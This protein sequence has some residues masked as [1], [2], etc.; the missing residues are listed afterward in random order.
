MTVLDTPTTTHSSFKWDRFTIAAACC[1]CM[2]VSALSIGLV[3]PQLR[4]QFHINGTITALHGSVL[5]VGLMF[6]GLFGAYIIGRL[7]RRGSL[8]TSMFGIA[9]G[10]LVFATGPSWPIT[11]AGATVAGFAAALMITVSPAVVSD[12]HGPHRAAAFS[13]LAAIPGFVGLLLSAAVGLALGAGASW[14]SPYL[15]F[16]AVIAVLAFSTGWSVPVPRGEPMHPFSF[17]RLTDRIVFVPLLQLMLAILT[18]FPVGMWSVTYLREV[19]GASAGAAPILGCAFA[20]AMAASRLWT[21]RLQR[22]LGRATVA[23]G[24]ATAA[25]GVALLCFVPVLW[26]RV[27]ALGVFAFGAGPL[28]PLAMDRLYQRTEHAIDPVTISTY[29]ALVNGLAVVVGPL[30]LGVVAD[31]VNLRWAVLASL[32]L[33]VVG[34]FIHRPRRSY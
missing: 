21:A 31:V 5:G 9:L 14:R 1:N 33:C 2:L 12:H 34:L 23:T 20:I 4:D 16:T 3:L 26:V 7:G 6:F 15:V 18:D 13:A 17:R 25:V 22:R 28:Y 11:L 32:T 30:V 10:V 19:G 24:Y 27:L 8:A 29:G